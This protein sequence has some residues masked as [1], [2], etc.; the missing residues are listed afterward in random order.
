MAIPLDRRSLLR[1]ALSGLAILLSI[2][3]VVFAIGLARLDKDIRTR[4]AGV[5]WTLPAQVYAAPQDLYAGLNLSLGN[6]AHE[7]RRLGYR[8]QASLDGPGTFTS[9]A[10]QVQIATRAFNFYD[11]AQPASQLK[12]TGAANIESVTDLASGSQLE[13]TRLDPLL[14]GSIYPARGGEDR[15]LIKLDE[16]PELLKKGLL[17]VED[18]GF[19]S[20]FGVSLRG[21][22]R[23]MVSNAAHSGR[24]QGASTITQQLVKNF[25]LTS[26][27]SY[28]R[29][30]KEVLMSVLLELHYSKDEI[31]EA[32]LNEIYMGQDAAR[33]VHG[34]GLASQFYFNKPLMELK[35]QEMAML[36]A[37][38]KGPSVYDPRRRPDLVRERRNL[39]LDIWVEE[40][41]ISKAD[42][43]N[44]KA[45][46]LGL[47]GSAKGGA[48][49]YPAFVDLVRR[50]LKDQY[51]DEAITTEGLRIY[52][53]LNPRVQ[54]ALEQRI[55]TDLPALEKS[56][57]QPAG[58]LEAAG[59]VT[60]VE[61]GEV[62]ALVAGRDVRYAGYNRAL[63]SRRS[64]G[65][66][67]KP[68]VYLTAL[69]DPAH[70]NL[71]TPIADEPVTV[72]LNGSKAWRPMNYDHRL[73]G[74]VP[75]YMALAHSYNLPTV[76][77]GMDVGT[78]AVQKTFVNAGFADAPDRPSMFLG[79]IDMSPLD[80]A[81]V[82][83]TLAA[84]GYQS[85]LSAIREVLTKDGEPL[86]RYPFKV[87]QT[88]PE[89]PVFLTTWA[90]HKVLEVGTATAAYSI[91]SPSVRLAGKTGTTDD[92]RDS[93]FA[94]F[95]ADHVGV[96]WV[97]RDDN[98]PS[99]FTGAAAA[100]PIW[101]RL[102][103]D[104]NAKSLDATPPADVEIS[105]SA[106]GAAA[107][108]VMA[109]YSAASEGCDSNGEQ[110]GEETGDGAAA[111]DTDAPGKKK[112]EDSPSNW[113]K[114]I[115][116]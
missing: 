55:V 10:G 88:L 46:P 28:R 13:L 59:V 69:S 40:G 60:S 22:L 7:L 54:E 95:S 113:L 83:N 75:L 86:K 72:K 67:A 29:K 114:E 56:R 23:A 38:V 82:Y 51:P 93:W 20:H 73:H 103:R 37:I 12:V 74:N 32:Y 2:L 66:L 39:A 94:G 19:Y 116:G 30:I 104:L 34:F 100:M 21:I 105:S 3:L 42:A 76:K 87:K 77:I 81:Q 96:I 17:A 4:F 92:L 24:K 68:F 44:A 65:S 26:E 49:R 85:Q 110:P 27:R 58:T 8:E 50:Q 15:A 115:F 33:A 99:G 107:I 91:I 47:S 101:A 64:I 57:R 63:D 90:M 16:A 31:L 62:Q 14:I 89:G 70:Y 5:R 25:F 80:V 79:A 106:C 11:G 35:P 36:V 102:M 45:L 53:S 98:K 109:G 61:G 108:P 9:A 111:P 6:L 41:I 18:R 48:E 97:G 52:T 112:K 84:S 78:R 1:Y 71:V 43:T